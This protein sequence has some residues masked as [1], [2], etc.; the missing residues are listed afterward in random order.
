M[1]TCVLEDRKLG[2]L[3]DLRHARCAN[4]GDHLREGTG[5]FGLLILE[6]EISHRQGMCIHLGY[7]VLL[8]VLLV[9]FLSK[10]A[11]CCTL[12]TYVIA[13]ST[14]VVVTKLEKAQQADS[15][16]GFI[17]EDHLQVTGLLPIAYRR[18]CDDLFYAGRVTHGESDYD[19]QVKFSLQDYSLTHGHFFKLIKR[20]SVD[21]SIVHGLSR[22]VDKR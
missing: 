21:L 6:K 10:F 8:G 1:P 17:R 11:M 14:S 9:N 3:L 22:R 18:I 15:L 16:R 4:S 19:L 13:W 12:P 20:E 2:W 7:L 5:C